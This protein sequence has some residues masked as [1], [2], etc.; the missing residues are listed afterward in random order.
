MR[1]LACDPGYERLGVAILEKNANEKERVLFSECI[2]TPKDIPF[3]DRL[4]MLGERIEFLYTEYAPDAFAI[5]TLFF[6]KNQK[7]AMQ[8][9][10]V[11]GMLLYIARM[12]KV[13]IFEYSPQA[14]KIAVTGHGGASKSSILAMLPRLV[15]LPEKKMIDDEL[16]AIAIA[17]TCLAHERKLQTS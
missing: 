10:E 11:R 5:E 14:I 1:T 2:H 9:A 4:Y 17:L 15:I 16:D 13:S 8:V 6:Q 3:V 12:R 7:T